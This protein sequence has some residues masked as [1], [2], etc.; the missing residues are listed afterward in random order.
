MSIAPGDFIAITL[1]RTLPSVFG[2]C[3]QRVLN[4]ISK[5]LSRKPSNMLL[6]HCHIILA[7]IFLLSSQGA[8]AKALNFVIQVL[9]ADATGSTIDIQSVVKSCVVPLL[10]ALVVVMGDENNNIAQQA[11]L[12]IVLSV[13]SEQ[14][15]LGSCR[16]QEG[17]ECTYQTD[18]EEFNSVV[19]F[20]RLLEDIYARSDI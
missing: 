14:D 4:A 6:K 18:A 3:D 20:R 17:R 10:A 13:W 2:T 7:H 11:R 12:L 8:T 9:T 19:G 1:P 5:E 16:A 15:I